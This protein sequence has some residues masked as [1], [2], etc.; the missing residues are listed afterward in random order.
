MPYDISSLKHIRKQLGLTQTEFARSAGVS[1]SLIAKIEAGNIDPT[2]SKVQKIFE[3]LDRLSKKKEASARELMQNNIMSAKPGDKV[4]ELVK[5][6]RRKGI[7]QVP[8]L[9][10]KN[11]IGLV[12]E[13]NIIEKLGDKDVQTLKAKDV[14]VDPPPIISQDTKMPVLK[15]LITHYPILVVARKG[16][17]AGVVTKS[18]ILSRI[19]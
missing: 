18:D 4:V 5:R 19:V 16:E 8:V 10:G 3:A 9:Q 1:Q 11:I 2:Y 15:S 7:S 14:M 12:T 13:H 17:L 6:M